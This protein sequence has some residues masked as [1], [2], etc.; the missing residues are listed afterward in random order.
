[1]LGGTR[2]M[3]DHGFDPAMEK[4]ELVLITRKHIPTVVPMQFG[5][6]EIQTK[7]AVK[8]LTDGSQGIS[9]NVGSKQAYGKFKRAKI[10]QKTTANVSGPIH[11]ALRIRNIGGRTSKEDLPERLGS[12]SAKG[13]LKN[14][15]LISYGIRTR[16]GVLP[17]DLMAQ[18]KKLVFERTPEVGK[19][20][21]KKEAR[22][23][24][25]QK[26][27]QRWDSDHRGRWTAR[28]I[29]Q[30]NTWLDRTHGEKNY[31]IMQFLAGHGYFRSYLYKRNKVSSP[32]CGY[33]EAE[34]GD[35]NHTFFECDHWVD[36][37]HRLESEIGKVTPDNIVGLMLQNEEWWGR[38]STTV[39]PL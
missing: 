4:T 20:I 13:G 36:L 29:Q 25:T 19:H 30:L 21:A 17:I 32:K 18:E 38:V 27:Q 7:P 24:F 34:E 31:Y 33:S 35:A 22:A 10:M 6:E 12:G 26:W 5:S 16:T 28:L 1:M 3:E 9:S 15:V 14:C 23:L 2:W 39:C 8:H 37:K 11:N